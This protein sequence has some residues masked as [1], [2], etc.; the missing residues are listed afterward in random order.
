MSACSRVELFVARDAEAAERLIVNEIAPRVHNSGHWTI[1]GAQTS[2]FEQHMRAIAGWP[3]G[4]TARRGAIEMRNLIGDDG[5]GMARHS[6]RA[7][8]LAAPLR[9]AGDPPRTQDGPCRARAAGGRA[10]ALIGWTNEPEF[11]SQKSN[12]AR[13]SEGVCAS[14]VFANSRFKSRR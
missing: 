6:R 12:E 14:V 11:A 5:G 9:Q 3:L 1:D 7:R 8:P 2:Q 10:A 13:R 4:S